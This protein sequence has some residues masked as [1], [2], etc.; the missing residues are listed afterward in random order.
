MRQLHRRLQPCKRCGVLVR[1]KNCARS[2]RRGRCRQLHVEL[3]AQ[4]GKTWV[5]QVREEERCYCQL[6][7]TGVARGISGVEPLKHLV[8]L[9]SN[10]VEH[11]NLKWPGVRI[12]GDEILE[13]GVGSRSVA[14][15][16]L[17]EIDGVIAPESFRLQL[18]IS[19]GLRWTVLKNVQNHEVA[20]KAGSVRLN[21]DSFAEQFLG[22]LVTAHSDGDP[23]DV[24]P[25]SS[26][27]RV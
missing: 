6:R 5:V 19:H 2:W 1:Q 20:V 26:E 16:L 14:L 15:R 10:S 8:G 17:C 23:A 13:H 7:E 11:S 25:R 27:E 9:L 18:R 12:P 3:L 22:F 21:L 24:V 4:C